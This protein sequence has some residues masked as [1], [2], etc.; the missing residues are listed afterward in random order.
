MTI[1]RTAWLRNNAREGKTLLALLSVDL[2]RLHKINAQ[3]CVGDYVPDRH[4]ENKTVPF[5]TTT[6]DPARFAD[7]ILAIYNLNLDNTHA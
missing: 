7:I 5:R 3:R 1:Y 4:L 2:H 6:L